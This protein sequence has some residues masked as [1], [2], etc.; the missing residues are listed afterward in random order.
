MDKKSEEENK[1]YSP[2]L[3]S[4]GNAKILIETKVKLINH[5]ENYQAFY[6]PVQVIFFKLSFNSKY[7]FRCSIE[8]SQFWF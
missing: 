3:I 4:E 8:I 5:E 2:K 6:N 7:F 1:E